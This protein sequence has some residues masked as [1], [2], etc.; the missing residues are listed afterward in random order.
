MLTIIIIIITAVI[1]I[2][3]FSNYNVFSKLQFNAYQVYHRKEWYRL[4]SHGFIHADWMHLIFNMISLFIFGSIVEVYL[5]SKVL[6]IFFYLSAIITA[7]LPTLIKQKD[8]AWY[9]SVGASGG[10][11]AMVFASILFNPLNK[12]LVFMI[13]IP[14]RAVIFGILYLWYSHYMSKHGHDNINHSAHFIGAIYGFAFPILINPG[15]FMDF[16]YQITHW[17]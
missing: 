11:S 1:S 2:S 13:P 9:N 17:F 7:S 15:F 3:S 4:L 14:I 6:F 16:I 5:D 12:L 10:V 8:N